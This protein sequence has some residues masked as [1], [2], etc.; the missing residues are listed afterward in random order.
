VLPVC[1]TPTVVYSSSTSFDF[2]ASSYV[3][4]SNI[5]AVNGDEVTFMV[6]VRSTAAGNLLSFALDNQTNYTVVFENS[7]FS[8]S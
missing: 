3:A 7:T 4:L 8:I 5:T 2:N 1:S 6:R